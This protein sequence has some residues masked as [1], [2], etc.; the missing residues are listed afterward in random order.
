MCDVHSADCTDY[1]DYRQTRA[2]RSR[3]ILT[4]DGTIEW[5]VSAN[6]GLLERVSKS[7]RSHGYNTQKAFGVIVPGRH[8]GYGYDPNCARLPGQVA[9]LGRGLGSRATRV[10]PS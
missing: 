3:L 4:A 2:A 1:E 7:G 5:H 8:L 10:T 9:G 6:R